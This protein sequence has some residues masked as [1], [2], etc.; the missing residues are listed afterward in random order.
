MAGGQDGE[1][2][3]MVEGAAG[4]GCGVV[5]EALRRLPFVP[6][7]AGTQTLSRNLIIEIVPGWVHFLDHLQLPLA[8]PFLD[9][10]FA[11][12]GGFTSLML[13]EPN[14]CLYTV[15]FR[16]TADNALPMLPSACDQ[17]V[18]HAGV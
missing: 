11:Q 12:Q 17:I 4:E 10:P 14:Q 18:G 2:A 15:F 5:A 3:R 7:Q 13:L 6:A 1:A 16:E 9:L 8:F